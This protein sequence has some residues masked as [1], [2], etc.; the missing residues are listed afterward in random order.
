[1]TI[2]PLLVLVRALTP[3]VSSRETTDHG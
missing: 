2:V 3:F 1:M